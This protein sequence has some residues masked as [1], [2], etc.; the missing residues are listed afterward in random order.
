MLKKTL[1]Y[2][3]TIYIAKVSAKR[4]GYNFKKLMHNLNLI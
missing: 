2:Y 1:K 4:I 3:K